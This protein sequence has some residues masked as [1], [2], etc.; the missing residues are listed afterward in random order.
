MP[1]WQVLFL[2]PYDVFNTKRGKQLQKHPPLKEDWHGHGAIRWF[3]SN[4]KGGVERE[5][6]DFS[7]PTNFPPELVKAIK[8]GR[9]WGFGIT[10]EM[11][12]MLRKPALAEY[13]KVCN[14]AL[15]ECDKVRNA[16]W[17]EYDKVRIA[18]FAN[19]FRKKANRTKAWQ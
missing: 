17:A 1:H 2:T 4:L 3:Y 7:S 6:T 9:M 19:L 12:A 5:C 10:N 16:A 15:A 13:D 11:R 8:A 14:A 18:A